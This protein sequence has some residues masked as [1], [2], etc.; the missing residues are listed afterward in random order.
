METH[1]G[2]LAEGT[3]AS[4]QVVR[5]DEALRSYA[6]AADSRLNLDREAFL[7]A[8]WFPSA[9]KEYRKANKGSERGYAGPTHASVVW[10]DIDRAGNLDQA[11]ADGRK[12]VGFLG[13]QAHGIPDDG[14]LVF[15]SGSKGLHIGCPVVWPTE[16]GRWFH[17]QARQFAVRIA[18]EV[19]VPI[20]ETLYDRCQL[21][22]APNTRHG[23]SGLYKVRLTYDELLNLN[24]DGIRG[25]AISPRPFDW[26]T[27]PADPQA[28][29]LTVYWTEAV[30]EAGRVENNRAE[31]VKQEQTITRS[32]LEVL[33]G[34]L[35]DLAAVPDSAKSGSPDCSRAVMLWRAAGNLGEC[36]VPLPATVGL[37][38]EAGMD[39]GLT[40]TEVERQIQSGW[41]RGTEGKAA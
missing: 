29:S 39:S 5:L 35:S 12:L 7:T 33:A 11:L 41:K 15:F 34:K 17:E 36:G 14:F 37:L 32:T 6:E 25:L 22:R 9:I 23:T 8:F 26:P 18:R 1:L 13:F 38:R 30:V 24:G 2:L 28:E 21:L 10:W 3:T 19:G 27:A 16:A 4:R 40:P 31:R 20:D